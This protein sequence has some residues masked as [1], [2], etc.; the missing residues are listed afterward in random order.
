MGVALNRTYWSQIDV[1]Q[2]YRNLH[3]QFLDIEEKAIY[4]IIS[5]FYKNNLSEK[6]QIRES[7]TLFEWECE[8][9][10][11]YDINMPKHGFITIFVT[12]MI[13]LIKKL[14]L[15]VMWSFFV[16]RLLS[17][18]MTIWSKVSNFFKKLSVAILQVDLIFTNQWI[19]LFYWKFHP[20]GSFL[21]E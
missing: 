21:N 17:D 7:S 9:K 14:S 8:V 12:K 6:S 16:I 10:F 4:R 19:S 5:V 2:P 11:L 13:M 20:R 18:L 3:A 15:Q 1:L